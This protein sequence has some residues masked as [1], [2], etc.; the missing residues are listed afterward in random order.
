MSSQLVDCVLFV[1][2]LVG[3]LQLVF[4]TRSY[5][6][7]TW[8]RNFLFVVTKI[9]LSWRGCGL[10]LEFTLT[11]C[12]FSCGTVAVW[13]L[14]YVIADVLGFH[15][16][17]IPLG[18]I[19]GKTGEHTARGSGV[20]SLGAV[21]E[22][23]LGHQE[24]GL[25]KARAFQEKGWALLGSPSNPWICQLEALESGHEWLSGEMQ[26]V[27]FYLLVKLCSQGANAFLKFMWC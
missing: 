8:G 17:S 20:H 21:A 15:C 1:S 18:S 6:M 4:W 5:K 19:R 22:I 12:T 10:L 9:L 11:D 26:G 27:P 7:N 25:L 23:D 3:V 14:F 2:T 24:K 13:G 16:T